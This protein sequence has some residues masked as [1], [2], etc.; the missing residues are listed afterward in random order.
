MSATDM[1]GLMPAK[2]MTSSASPR[3]SRASSVEKMSETIG[4]TGRSASGKV[5]P[6]GSARH[7]ASTASRSRT[8]TVAARTG[9]T[10]VDVLDIDLLA[11]HPL[12]QGGGH[13]AVEVAVEHVARG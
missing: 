11:R 6:C 5:G 4:A 10:L 13:E 3:R 9:N 8:G 1:P 7:D 2:A 12:R